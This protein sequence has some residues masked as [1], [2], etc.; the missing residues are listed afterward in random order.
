MNIPFVQELLEYWS[1]WQNSI[2][3]VNLGHKRIS[4]VKRI[5]DGNAK[6]M[7]TKKKGPLTDGIDDEFAENIDKLIA[8]LPPT[9]QEII[10][11]YYL[12]NNSQVTVAQRLGINPSTYK[13]RMAIAQGQIAEIL[14]Q[15]SQI[16]ELLS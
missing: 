7:D 16:R 2:S 3:G 10:K 8:S 6:S 1:K 5:M 11:L 12:S 9:S 15:K 4:T 13:K 14:L